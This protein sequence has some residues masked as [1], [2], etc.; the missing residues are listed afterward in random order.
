MR[1]ANLVPGVAQVV[2][3]SV[4]HSDEGLDG[5]NVLLLHFG[6]TR[7]GRQQGEP[8]QSLHIGIPLQLLQKQKDKAVCQ[9]Y[10]KVRDTVRH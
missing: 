9:K 10:C 8:C 6:D 5:V 7:A 2:A 4:G 1:T 3:V